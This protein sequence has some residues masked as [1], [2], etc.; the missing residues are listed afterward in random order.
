MASLTKLIFTNYKSGFKK[1]TR[2]SGP[3]LWYDPMFLNLLVIFPHGKDTLKTCLDRLTNQQLI[4]LTALLN[5][6]IKLTVIIYGHSKSTTFSVFTDIEPSRFLVVD[7]LW[8]KS[9]LQDLTWIVR[10]LELDI[11]KFK[12]SSDKTNN[13]L[14]EG[15]TYT[16]L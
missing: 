2:N 11:G 7:G 14:I 13:Y 4:S 12:P 9:R 6:G 16:Q 15:K 5:Q 3:Q 8:F 10:V 1:V